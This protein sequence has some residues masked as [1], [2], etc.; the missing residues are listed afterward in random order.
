[1]CEGSRTMSPWSVLKR[2]KRPA[3]AIAATLFVLVAAANAVV[4]TQGAA[5]AYARPNEVPARPVAIVLGARVWDDG[6]PSD[7]LE[8]RLATALAL[9]RRGA[10]RHILV[11]G[12][13]GSNR[14]DEVTVMQRWLLDRGVDPKAVVRDHAGFRTH[15]SMVRAVEVFGVR[16]AV[17]CTQRFHM[18]RSL[19]LAR[20]AGI[21]AVG[22][23][24]DRR[25]YRG[26]VKNALREL[27]ARAVAVGDVWV[28][29]RRPRFLGPR[30]PIGA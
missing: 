4:L 30:I 29:R 10:V 17:V 18:A 7:V 20:A 6:T 1:M 22:A 26:R 11:T 24:S 28:W 2:A 12:D 19:F 15:D 27:V 21:D 13:N 5:G 23:L 14:Y 9:Y 25:R 16:R 3:M 8:D